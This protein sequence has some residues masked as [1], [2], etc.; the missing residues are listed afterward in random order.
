MLDE[1]IFAGLAFRFSLP[2]FEGANYGSGEMNSNL[3]KIVDREKRILYEERVGVPSVSIVHT[4]SES[5]AEGDTVEFGTRLSEALAEDVTLNLVGTGSAEYGSS[6]DYTVSVGGTACT[7]TTENNYQVVIA[8]GETSANVTISI[9]EGEHNELDEDINLSIEIVSTESLDL[10]LGD[11]SLSF[12]IS[13]DVPVPIVSISILP[14][15]ALQE[16]SFG[17]VSV[18]LSGPASDDVIV[19]LFGSGTAE[20]GTENDWNLD[21][22]NAVCDDAEQAGDCSVTISRGDTI[23]AETITVNFLIDSDTEEIETATVTIAVDSSSEHLVQ[24]G[25]SSSVNFDIP[26]N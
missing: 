13:A 1:R 21:I 7:G 9:V 19:N 11:S 2:D 3:Y 8:M 5:V 6:N 24:L 14:G 23:P 10:M 16:G 17:G 15:G 18:S 12:T 4:G 25:S 22:A 26:A 20:Y